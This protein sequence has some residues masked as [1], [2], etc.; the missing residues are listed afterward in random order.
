MTEE[1]EEDEEKDVELVSDADFKQEKEADIEYLWYVL[2][3][4]STYEVIVS[5]I[6][7]KAYSHM[8]TRAIVPKR[9]RK[10]LKKGI[11][12]KTET[13]IYSGYV[14]IEVPKTKELFKD[15]RTLIPLDIIKM[16]KDIAVKQEF[17]LKPQ[18]DL[19]PLSAQEVDDFLTM[20]QKIESENALE[21][22]SGGSVDG[23]FVVGQRV[24]LSGSKLKGSSGFVSDIDAEN[25]ELHVMVSL[26]GQEIC[27]KVDYE[28][29]IA[30]L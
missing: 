22:S 13:K 2:V 18:N 1:I 11:E 26:F 30:I 3:I 9:I 6:I 10:V 14:L 20:F 8:I 16:L 7:M 17:V 15:N 28:D 23:D 24:H 4:P 25:K 5:Q 27:I 19:Y 21:E 29:V 12:K